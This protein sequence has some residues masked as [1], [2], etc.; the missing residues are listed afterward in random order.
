MIQDIISGIAKKLDAEYDRPVYDD[1]TKQDLKGPCFYI[2]QIVSNED[3]LIGSRYLRRYSLDVHYFPE[4]E[5]A[6]NAEIHGVQEAL[7]ELLEYVSMGTDLVRG[8]GM[9]HE[10]QAG[11]MHFFV[12]YDLT[13]IKQKPAD[14]PMETLHIT[15][16]LA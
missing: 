13:I 6:P 5:N 11:V 7:Y 2:K 10:I 8:K 15:Q 1:H 4:S 9:R 16:E 14:D 3:Q 12:S